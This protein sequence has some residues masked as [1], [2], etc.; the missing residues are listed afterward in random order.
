MLFVGFVSLV[1]SLVFVEGGDELTLVGF[2]LFFPYS[3]ENILTYLFPPFLSFF[4]LCNIGSAES[5]RK[6]KNYQS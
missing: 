6:F 2:V 3:S 4:P 5:Q 1:R